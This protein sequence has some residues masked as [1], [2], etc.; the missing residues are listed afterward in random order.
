MLLDFFDRRDDGTFVDVGAN[1]PVAGSTSWPLEQAGWGG[2]LVEPIPLLADKL[3]K[4]RTGQVF[5]CACSREEDA[6]QSHT[7]YVH[8]VI[9][10]WST[11]NKEASPWLEDEFEEIEV[12]VRTLDSILEEAGVKEGFEILAMDVE[13]HEVKVLEGLDLQRWKP[14]VIFVEDHAHD[15]NLLRYLTSHG[16]KFLNRTSLNSWF[17]PEDSPHSPSAAARYSFLRKY[18]LS[19]PFRSLK[20]WIKGLRN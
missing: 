8:P 13:F 2:V 7:F 16:Y 11:F 18:Y 14:Q 3:R 17:V 20:H 10:G 6:G 5:N 19:L 4:E 15:H 12:A 9:P 1:E